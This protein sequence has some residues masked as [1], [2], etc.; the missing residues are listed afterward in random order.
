MSG[1][2]P[3]SSPKAVDDRY[4]IA[5]HAQPR[6]MRAGLRWVQIY[7][8]FCK[9][10]YPKCSHRDPT[11][12]RGLRCALRCWED[13]YR[14]KQ[15]TPENVASPTQ[16]FCPFACSL[17]SF[18]GIS[19]TLPPCS[20]MSHHVLYYYRGERGGP[21]P[22]VRSCGA[23]GWVLRWPEKKEPNHGT[24]IPRFGTRTRTGER[25]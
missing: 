11:P 8:D 6:V 2:A 21:R 7:Q 13:H 15:K 16:T 17:R 14:V 22:A 24:N 23:S 5:K 10:R 3:T 18:A 12:K 25:E 20:F 1:R 9:T 19:N 4:E